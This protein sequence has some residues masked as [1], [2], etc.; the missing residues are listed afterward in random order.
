MT[1]IILI[2]LASFSIAFVFCIIINALLGKIRR[3][4]IL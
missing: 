2:V 3:E 4:R 1:R